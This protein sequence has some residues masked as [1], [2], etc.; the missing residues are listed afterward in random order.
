M[1]TIEGGELTLRE[2]LFDPVVDLPVRKIVKMEYEVGRTR[3]NGKV[4]RSVPGV[5]PIVAAAARVSS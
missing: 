3:S 2:S 5:G 4:L 1:R